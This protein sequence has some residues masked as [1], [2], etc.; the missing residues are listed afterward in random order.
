MSPEK[1]KIEEGK[2]HPKMSEAVVKM[3]VNEFDNMDFEKQEDKEKLVICHTPLP[4]ESKETTFKSEYRTES[5]TLKIARLGDWSFKG[6]EEEIMEELQSRLWKWDQGVTFSKN[7]VMKYMDDLF[8]LENGSDFGKWKD[9]LKKKAS[10]IKIYQK[11]NGSH[12]TKAFPYIMIEMTLNKSYT[13]DQVVRAFFDHRQK[14]DGENLGSHVTIPTNHPNV[15]LIHSIYKGKVKT[16]DKAFF[17][18]RLLFSH[19]NETVYAYM[20]QNASCASDFEEKDLKRP[21]TDTC[22]SI[23]CLNKFF[24][25]ES[26]GKIIF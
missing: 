9:V 3:I 23:I 18:K 25:R 22:D 24:R 15:S 10:P 12:H 19:N 6:D 13:L 26:D 16:N 4:E 8:D 7:G 14:W 5:G 20:T 17:D 1:V 21:K 2:E 11:D